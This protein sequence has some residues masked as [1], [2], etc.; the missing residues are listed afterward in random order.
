MRRGCDL[1]LLTYEADSV[2]G[3]VSSLFLVGHTIEFENKIQ[4]APKK[5][6]NQGI[7]SLPSANIFVQ[8]NMT[9]EQQLENNR[10]WDAKTQLMRVWQS[11]GV[12]IPPP[13]LSFV[14]VLCCG[15][16]ILKTSKPTVDQCGTALC[17]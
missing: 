3:I 8:R 16:E 9:N 12:F 14:S 13:L 1:L 15:Y 4:K 10:F 11:K 17:F 5:K 2:H 6:R 7:H